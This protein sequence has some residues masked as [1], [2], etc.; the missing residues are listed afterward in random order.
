[1]R[2]AFGLVRNIRRAA[3][4]D[5]I[6][7]RLSGPDERRVDAVVSIYREIV[8]A[9]QGTAGVEH[10]DDVGA[11]GAMRTPRLDDVGVGPGLAVKGQGITRWQR[12]SGLQI[13]H[14]LELVDH[15][16]IFA[17]TRRGER[18]QSGILDFDR[19]VRFRR[20]HARRTQGQ[21]RGGY[22]GYR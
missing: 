13:L 8:D 14:R 11:H 2:T 1:S 6:V 12:R 22:A 10:G 4:Q 19:H 7:E 21:H 17:V 16:E 5:Y 15:E 9:V 3:K 20:D 18:I